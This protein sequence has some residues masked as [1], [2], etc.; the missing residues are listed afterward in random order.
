MVTTPAAPGQQTPAASATSPASR[1][2]A[3][4]RVTAVPG[5]Q[6]NSAEPTVIAFLDRYFT[7]INKHNY[8]AYSRLLTPQL[9]RVNTHATFNSGYATTTDSAE[10]LTSIADTSDGIAAT[11]S[12]TS[13]QNPASS[14]T[15][16]SCTSWTIILYLEPDGSSYLIRPAPS[17]YRAS[18]QAC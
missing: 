3:S 6:A 11:A 16:T 7:A 17:G 12:F 4:V 2:A 18:Y 1:Q 15:H 8:A 13:N 10:T 5:V 9:Q 14:I